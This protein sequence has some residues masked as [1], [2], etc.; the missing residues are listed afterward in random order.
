MENEAILENRRLPLSPVDSPYGTESGAIRWARAFYDAYRHLVPH[1]TDRF[2]VEA[3]FVLWST[4]SD[5]CLPGEARRPFKQVLYACARA[6]DV[7]KVEKD[8]TIQWR[9]FDRP[10]E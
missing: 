7:C 3:H 10:L 8:G 5:F 1:M 2:E 6:L 9:H 4:H